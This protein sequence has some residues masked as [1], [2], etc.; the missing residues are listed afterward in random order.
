M[1]DL[2][3]ALDLSLLRRLRTVSHVPLSPA[4][5]GPSSPSLRTRCVACIFSCL[6]LGFIYLFIFFFCFVCAETD[7]PGNDAECIR[8]WTSWYHPCIGLRGDVGMSANW[9]DSWSMLFLCGP[10]LQS[11]AP[12]RVECKIS[13]SLQDSLLTR[14]SLS[15]LSCSLHVHSVMLLM[16]EASM[17]FQGSLVHC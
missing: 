4:A 16:W 9:S 14:V 3:M 10:L 6:M 5:R 7:Q 8:G 11:N 17:V 12:H 1:L 2:Q 13:S 15:S